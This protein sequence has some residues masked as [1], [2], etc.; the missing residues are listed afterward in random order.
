M[1]YFCYHF[2]LVYGYLLSYWIYGGYELINLVPKIFEREKQSMA[3]L[4]VDWVPCSGE[5]SPC[6]CAR[7]EQ[8]KREKIICTNSTITVKQ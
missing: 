2:S 6:V 7:D 4:S 1:V 5:S 8:P 3:V